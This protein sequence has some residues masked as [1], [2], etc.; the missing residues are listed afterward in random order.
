MLE[1]CLEQ[2]IID[3]E[4]ETN[5]DILRDIIEACARARDVA[6]YKLRWPVR[7]IVIV[8]E[9]HRVTQ[10]VEALTDVLTEQA[11]TKGVQ[12]LEEFEGLKVLASP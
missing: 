6:R 7:E 10:A 2:E 4:L 8:T 3:Q 5:M 9:D 11:N 12:I 1:W